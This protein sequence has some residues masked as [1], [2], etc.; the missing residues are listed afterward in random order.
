MSEVDRIETSAIHPYVH[1]VKSLDQSRE[2]Y[3]HEA[4]RNAGTESKRILYKR[5]R[6]PKNRPAL[7][8][9]QNYFFLAVFFAAFFVDFFAAF[10]V[11]FLAAFFAAMV[12]LPFDFVFGFCFVALLREAFGFSSALSNS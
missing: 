10:L 11:A 3:M 6:G 8:K 7:S 1:V 9:S 12:I 4:A 2:R 5:K